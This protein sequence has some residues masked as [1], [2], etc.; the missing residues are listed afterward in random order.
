MIRKQ[1]LNIHKYDTRNKNLLKVLQQG[2]DF[3]DDIGK[4][5]PLLPI[6]PSID[7]DMIRRKQQIDLMSYKQPLPKWMN[8]AW[9][10]FRIAD[11]HNKSIIFLLPDEPKQDE[12]D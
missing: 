10:A 11:N 6:F 2:D 4:P 8:A 12:Y 5:Q 9:D 7:L 3:I 1:D